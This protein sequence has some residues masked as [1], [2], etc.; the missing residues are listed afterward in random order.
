MKDQFDE[1]K[2]NRQCLIEPK[3]LLTSRTSLVLIFLVQLKLPGKT[4]LKY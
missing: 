2:G 4:E 1:E 3:Q